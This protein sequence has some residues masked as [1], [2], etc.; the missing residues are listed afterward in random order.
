MTQSQ[1]TKLIRGACYWCK[2]SWSKSYEI[3]LYREDGFFL[4]F[5]SD[6]YISILE[7]DDLY[8]VCVEKHDTNLTLI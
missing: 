4:G 8:P 6:E 1:R 2:F 7:F 3:F 5:G